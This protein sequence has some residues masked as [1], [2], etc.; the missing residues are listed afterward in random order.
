MKY[1]LCNSQ[2]QGQRFFFGNIKIFQLV[3]RFQQ[4]QNNLRMQLTLNMHPLL[5]L[6]KF[7]LIM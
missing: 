7:Q 3:G 1:S 5:L 6:V 4:F 2:V